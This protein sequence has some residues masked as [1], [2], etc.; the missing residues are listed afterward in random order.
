ML[1]FCEKCQHFI[2]QSYVIAEQPSKATDKI[3]LVFDETGFT[4]QNILNEA[5]AIFWILTP[6]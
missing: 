1:E 2:A 5:L 3:V 6:V 4:F